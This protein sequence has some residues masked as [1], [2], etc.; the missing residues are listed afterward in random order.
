MRTT[1]IICIQ[2]LLGI[3]VSAQ[4][5]QIVPDLSTANDS[6]LWTVFNRELTIEE[7]VV[8]LN[9]KPNDGVIMV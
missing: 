2:I 6:K 5:K 4:Q 8:Y 1:I 3:S 9:A 7:K